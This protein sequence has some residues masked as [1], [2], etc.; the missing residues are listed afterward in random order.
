M[1]QPKTLRELRDFI[2][3]VDERFLDKPFGLQMENDIHHVH[4]MESAVDDHYYDPE[5]PG[6]GSMPLQEWRDNYSLESTFPESQ[7]KEFESRLKIGI[8]I[9]A[10]IFTEDF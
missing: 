7:F 1:T 10:P 8:P 5:N 9:G 6:D 3:T 4:F 2:N